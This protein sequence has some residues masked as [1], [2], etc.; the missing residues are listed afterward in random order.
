MYINVYIYTCI[1]NYTHIPF[2][3][4]ICI[5]IHM[6]CVVYLCALNRDAERFKRRVAVVHRDDLP[7]VRLVALAHVLGEGQRR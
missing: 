6:P 5:H 3:L 4:Y 2:V 7:A 1:Y